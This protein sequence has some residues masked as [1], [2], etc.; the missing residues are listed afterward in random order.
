MV[1][2]TWVVVLWREFEYFFIFC[3][4]VGK[5]PIPEEKEGGE[6][7]AEKNKQGWKGREGGGKTE[8]H[9]GSYCGQILL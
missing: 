5:L 8:R 6:E 9:R 2:K 1:T 4:L 7:E 3:W